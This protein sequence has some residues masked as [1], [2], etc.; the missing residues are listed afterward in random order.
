MSRACVFGFQHVK[1]WSYR[2]MSLISS[3]YG[4]DDDNEITTALYMI[5]NVCPFILHTIISLTF[6]GYG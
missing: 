1:S 3:I 5:A 2:P 6:S 4:S